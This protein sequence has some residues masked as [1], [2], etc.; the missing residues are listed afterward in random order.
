[1]GERLPV[2]KYLLVRLCASEPRKLTAV[3][4]LEKFSVRASNPRGRGATIHS[5]P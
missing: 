4:K 3:N 5:A 1:M 2:L